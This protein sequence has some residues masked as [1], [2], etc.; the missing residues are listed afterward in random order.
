MELLRILLGAPVEWLLLSREIESR[1]I[2]FLTYLNEAVDSRD[3]R[4]SEK[5]LIRANKNM[6]M[7]RSVD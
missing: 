1:L 7:T 6:E 2:E 5:I 4:T 3:C